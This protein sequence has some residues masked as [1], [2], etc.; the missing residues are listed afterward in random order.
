MVEILSAALQG[1]TFL[2]AL[3]GIGA[4]GSK[5]PYHLGHFFIVINPEFFVGEKEFRKT[6]GD[7]LRELRAS[8][9]APGEPRIF[10]PGEKAWM[11]SVWRADKGVPV[12]EAVQKEFIELRD[13]YDLDYK[14]PFED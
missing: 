1:G 7:I 5:Q 6:A 13:R 11:T 3:S 14:F 10:T 2:K 8:E 4:D 12:G 9:K